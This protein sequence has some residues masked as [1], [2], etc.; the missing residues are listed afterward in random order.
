ME[1]S[2]VKTPPILDWAVVSL[3]GSSD[4]EQ[5]GDEVPFDTIEAAVNKLQSLVINEWTCQPDDDF[6]IKRKSMNFG[7]PI[8]F[9]NE[10]KNSL[11]YM[12]TEIQRNMRE[13]VLESGEKEDLF[14]QFSVCQVISEEIR[15][16]MQKSRNVS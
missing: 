10:D 1:P 5:A 13:I 14:E 8:K 3:P 16:R 6:K 9:P 7:D 11:E 12:F 4:E 2:R 15:K